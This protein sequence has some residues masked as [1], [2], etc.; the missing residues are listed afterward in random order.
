MLSTLQ[1]GLIAIFF[2]MTLGGAIV[3]EAAEYRVGSLSVDH[4]WARASAGPAKSGVTYLMISNEG[5]TTDRLVKIETPVAMKASLHAHVVEN[6]IM[7]MGPIKA[8]EVS[9]GAPVMLKPGGTHIML[10]GLKA[11][12][13]EGQMFPM[14]LTFAK[15]GRVNVKVMVHG[16]GAMM[17]PQ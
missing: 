4:V 2:T 16:P 15:A 17:H 12:L 5:E 8:I 3:A 11:P 6:G 7:K 9:P 14:T 10:M 13:K 1:R